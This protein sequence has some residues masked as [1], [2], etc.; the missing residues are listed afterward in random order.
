MTVYNCNICN[1]TTSLKGNHTRH[2]KTKKHMYNI[3]NSSVSNTNQTLSN[4]LSNTNQ[5]L[6]N[7]LSNTNQTLSNNL[8]NTN[9]N[10]DYICKYCSKKFNTNQSYYRH[11]KHYCNKNTKNTN[12]NNNDKQLIP[13]DDIISKEL[14]DKFKS[15][16]ES[17]YELIPKENNDTSIIDTSISNNNSHNT[18]N[19]NSNNT[20]N[21][22]NTTINNIT[23]KNFG[24]ER[25][26]HIKKEHICN[27]LKLPYEMIPKLVEQVHFNDDVPENKN[28]ELVNKKDKYIKIMEKGKWVYKELDDVLFELVDSKSYFI[29][30]FFEEI[31]KINKEELDN[32]L[33]TYER[34]AY[35]KFRKEYD[36]IGGNDKNSKMMSDLKT[37]TFLQILLCR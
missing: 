20:N 11:M 26:D 19:N 31:M 21:T 5:T 22:N 6:S 35:E 28:I 36:D 23:I 12:R 24:H 7:N 27:L 25:M 16:I 32:L 33:T 9:L 8:S 10:S 17:K 29:D 30:L 15:M 4:N 34:E 14:Y 13:V 1:F 37:K 18:L 3:T 2:L